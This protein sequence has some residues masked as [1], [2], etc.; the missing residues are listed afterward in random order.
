MG[1]LALATTAMVDN[2]DEQQ[3]FETTRTRL[4]QI[5]TAIIGD[6]SRT[7]N[8]EPMISG[9]VADM[10]RLPA[11]IQELVELPSE[12]ME[13]KARVI[14]HSG[15]EVGQ[16]YGGWRGPYLDVMPSSEISA[17]RA[18]RDGWGNPVVAGHESNFG[19]NVISGVNAL[20]IQSY[21]SDGR[22]GGTG[23]YEVDYPATGNLVEASDWA[24]GLSSVNFNLT[25]NK[26]PANDQINLKLRVYFF[27]D[28]GV[29]YED[30]GFFT[31]SGV[32]S[33]SGVQPVPVSISPASP[34]H[35][36]KYLAVIV[37][38]KDTTF[39]DVNPLDDKLFNGDCNASS[40]THSPYY[41]AL[42][43]KMQLPI[44]IT[45]NIQ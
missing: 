37:C 16:L 18:F 8:G 22:V 9:F 23:V 6:T 12:G 26:S 40:A 2:A 7:L 43:P 33:V 21:G 25:F 13:W 39:P 38:A 27:E 5:K 45:W 41:F 1:M 19:W 3:R 17:V 10:G 4:Q 32:A 14:T 36:G 20:S 11:N 24:L 15:V 42:L 34:L 35:M 30:S 44:P 31:L 29:D 28:T